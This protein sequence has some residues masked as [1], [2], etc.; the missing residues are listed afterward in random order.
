M[1]QVDKKQEIDTLVNE[2]IKLVSFVLGMYFQSEKIMER[3]DM[4]QYGCIGLYT[5]CEKWANNEFKNKKYQ[6][7]TM[8]IF[9]IRA[10]ISHALDHQYRKYIINFEEIKR[11]YEY[12]YKSQKKS[13]NI[14][15]YFDYLLNKNIISKKEYEF[16]KYKMDGYLTKDIKQIMNISSYDIQ[17]IF[18]S[19]RSKIDKKDIV[20]LLS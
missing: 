15:F 1:K 13:Y 17:K 6:F 10:Y 7:S 9:Y 4:F 19:L 12:D 16:V 20:D 11:T 3:E 14:R 18:K 8:A 2:N 5:F